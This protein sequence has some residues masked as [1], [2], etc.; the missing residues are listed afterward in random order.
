MRKDL[1]TVALQ[2]FTNTYSEAIAI[3]DYRKLSLA[4]FVFDPWRHALRLLNRPW[5][6]WY[7]PV[8]RVYV[9]EIEA[10]LR[11]Q[12]A[13]LIA[14]IHES[15]A[16]LHANSPAIGNFDSIE[17]AISAFATQLEKVERMIR[18]SD[19][20][21]WPWSPN[22]NRM[23]MLQKYHELLK[24]THDHLVAVF[25]DAGVY[26]IMLNR[27][28]NDLQPLRQTFSKR[29]PSKFT[30]TSS[31]A[32]PEVLVAQIQN[33]S[34]VSPWQSLSINQDSDGSKVF[35]IPPNMSLFGYSLNNVDGP[36]LLAGRAAIAQHCK[37]GN[38]GDNLEDNLYTICT[39]YHRL[40]AIMSGLDNDA[41]SST[42]RSWMVGRARMIQSFEKKMG[43]DMDGVQRAL[44]KMVDEGTY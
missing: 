24:R 36:Q 34:L 11:F 3:S 6:T 21:R 30:S 9:F 16:V 12:K 10:E 29:L 32:V 37:E 31:L 4:S 5:L 35:D 43:W 22:S 42:A 20:S 1:M 44:E 8:P 33:V 13:R 17:E 15:L 26:E 19:S 41:L 39:I 28:W 14:T 25:K 23:S 18:E 27:L 7:L 2:S 40:A 38:I